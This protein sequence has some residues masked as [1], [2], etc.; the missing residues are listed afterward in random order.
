MPTGLLAR[1][2]REIEG[3]RYAKVEAPPT[4]PKISA[5][6]QGSDTVIFGG[7]NGQFLIE[8]LQR[9]AVG[10]MP[11]SD[12]TADYVEVWNRLKAND[13]T[14][15]W[16]RFTRMLPLIRFELQ[17]GMGVS[18]MKHNLVAA[19]VIRSVKVRHPTAELDERS[20]A[21]LAFLR[22]WTADAH[23]ESLSASLS[24]EPRYK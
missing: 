3:V 2:T 21:E 4:A 23:G 15:A 11:G 8:E 9:G 12:M 14:G 17:P 19:G 1:M 18:A 22:R 16:Q 13:R 7:L 24:G 6:R 10:T 5:L 20:L